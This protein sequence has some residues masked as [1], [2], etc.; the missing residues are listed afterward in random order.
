MVK[1]HAAVE[2]FFYVFQLNILQL[3]LA[4]VFYI[5]LKLKIFVYFH[6]QGEDQLFFSL[7]S[8]LFHCLIWKQFWGY[9]LTWKLVM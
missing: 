5:D 4:W 1:L 9:H 7:G 3:S 8:C 2:C 6:L